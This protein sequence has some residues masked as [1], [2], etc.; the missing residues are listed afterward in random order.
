MTA[1]RRVFVYGNQ[2][3]PSTLIQSQSTTKASMNK[4]SS[5]LSSAFLFHTPGIPWARTVPR[6]EILPKF[7]LDASQ[8][9]KLRTTEFLW[10]FLKFLSLGF[11]LFVYL[12]VLKKSRE[13]SHIWSF[14]GLN[15][16]VD[17][18]FDFSFI[19]SFLQYKLSGH[20]VGILHVGRLC[21]G[22]NDRHRLSWN[23]F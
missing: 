17:L 6:S 12:F 9:M 4:V 2:G 20:F 8:T 23:F 5:K 10:L 21:C 15:K 1:H 14:I 19:L 22:W 3:F 11:C 7:Q 13:F 16:T 18:L